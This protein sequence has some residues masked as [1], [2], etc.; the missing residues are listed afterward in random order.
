[1]KAT[2]A[3][4]TAR[5]APKKDQQSDGNVFFD[6]ERSN[7]FFG[8][9]ET[10]PK[11]FFVQRK[12]SIGKPDDHYEKQADQVADKVV[13]RMSQSPSVQAKAATPAPTVTPVQPQALQMKEEISEEPAGE[14]KLQRKPIFDSMGDPPENSIQRKP[15]FDSMGDS[16]QRK[17]EG[18]DAKTETSPS[19]ESRLNSTKGS[20]SPLP[21]DT[22]SAMESSI[23]ADFSGV[24]IH[25]GTEA[26]ALSND[27]QAQA[28]T[29]GKDIY[30]NEGKYDS[31]SSSGRHL[32]AHELTH[33]VQQGAAVQK[34]PDMT[35]VSASPDVQLAPAKPATSFT[36]A[37]AH[38][39][40]PAE[41]VN[42]SSG[43]FNPSFKLREQ[44][45]ATKERGLEIKISAGK[46]A[47]DGIIKVREEKGELESMRNDYLP[48]NIPIFSA[49]NPALAVQLIKGGIKGYATIA[50]G[51]ADGIPNWLRAHSRELSWLTGIELS[52]IP[53]P[54]TN[55]FDSAGF[56]FTLNGVNVK[57]GGLAQARMDIGFVNLKPSVHVGA[58][59]D[60]AGIVRAGFDINMSKDGQMSGEG[61]FDVTYKGFGGKIAAR[62]N[63]G[64]LDVKGVVGYSGDRL[65]GSLTLI[66]TDK[67]TA[68]NFAKTQL[69]GVKPED[70]VMPEAVP[71]VTEGKGPRGMAGIGSLTFNMTEWFAGSVNVIVDG[72]GFVTVIG[73]IAPPKEIKLFEQ[74]N[75]DK[76]LFKLSATAGYGIPVLG[77]IGIFAEVSLSA[78]SRIGP[79]K[80]YNIEVSGTY[81]NNPDIA[82]SISL[83][84]SLNISAYAGLRLRAAGGAIITLLG[85]DLKAGVGVNADAGVKGY[86]DARPTIGYRDP[87]EFF[88]KGHM[89]IAAQPVLGLSGDFFV[90]LDSPWYSPLPDKKW[91]WPIG[92]LEYPLPG[93]F[94]IGADVDYVLG[95][96]K[97]PDIKFTDANFDGSKFMTDLV[98]DNVPKKSGADKKDKQGKFV[99][100]GAAK[101]AKGGKVPPP[102]KPGSKP[103]P[104]PKSGGKG[105]DKGAGKLD[106]MKNFAE[107]MK[108]VKALEGH[109]P[110]T[111]AEITS[112]IEA[113]K[114]QYN[115]PGIIV[116]PQGNDRWKITG[117]LAGKKNKQSV[118]V[119]ANMKAGDEKVKNGDEA[120]KGNELSKGLAALHE[121]DQA[122]A[123]DGILEREEAQ[124]VAGD[125]RDAKDSP[126]K[127]IT[128]LES[129]DHWEY[130]YVQKKN[131]GKE[132]GSKKGKPKKPVAGLRE[133]G[134]IKR[135]KD[136]FRVVFYDRQED[137]ILVNNILTNQD[138]D[139]WGVSY[140]FDKKSTTDENGKKIKQSDRLEVYH[141]V[142]PEERT[143]PSSWG[144]G[145]KGIRPYLYDNMHG[146]SSRADELKFGDKGEDYQRKRVKAFQD[147]CRRNLDKIQK[148]EAEFYELRDGDTVIDFDLEFYDFVKKNS[149]YNPMK[150]NYSVDHNP[151]LSTMWN[152]KGRNTD[153]ATRRS[154]VLGEKGGGITL[155]VITARWNSHLGGDRY[156]LTVGKKFTSVLTDPEG[157]TISKKPGDKPELFR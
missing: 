134:L 122:V 123:G 39:A 96:G 150:I 154:Q 47:G 156:K 112:T 95:S 106:E 45:K 77:M 81:S 135:G 52:S 48:L 94:G 145:S 11:P 133:G 129:G 1:M 41:V 28:F 110:M 16:I 114:N 117:S 27:L 127:S 157:L 130:Y 87:G 29:H 36:Q 70:A 22:R 15:I 132:K 152:L 26:A 2:D 3:K 13:Q 76:E 107:A 57:V 4:S 93:E 66:M 149:N 9:S 55:T 118:Y 19:V 54:G 72:K 79:A 131:D 49:A 7:S 44:I 151:A 35:A 73:K 69:A 108:K 51:K 14:E 92:S 99:D 6:K 85:H 155:R 17:S 12:L 68:D 33:T 50:G 53:S 5:T 120:R 37:S 136:I 75:Y 25:T 43:I 91:S 83:S 121:K 42:V 98:D 147:K 62:F 74:S 111:R 89:E 21:S 138:K 20:G 90:E 18:S 59:M 102:A 61:G 115:I 101:P 58:I 119:P 148:F 128:V 63:E 105:K 10:E 34:K 71:A 124:K 116:I 113:I 141:P 146:W 80:I 67:K 137:F 103:V 140:L 40:I 30:F 23:G 65:S 31:S 82:K 144:S 143:L 38:T 46:L 153:D 88:F 24:R 126:F 8:E 125:I 32:L 64:M 104:V 100:G 109:K 139:F 97:V 60:V 142:I 56:Q 86:V 84:G 78:I